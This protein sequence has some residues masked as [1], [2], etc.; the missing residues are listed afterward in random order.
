MSLNNVNI[1][2]FS[3]TGGTE[4]AAQHVT[5]ALIN[6]DISTSL[7]EIFQHNITTIELLSTLV[8]MFPVYALDAPLPIYKWINSLPS[9]KFVKTVII[10]VSGGGEVSPNTDCRTRIIKL[11]ED[12]GFEITNEYMLCMP[13]NFLTPTPESLSNKL[14]QILPQKCEIIAHEIVNGISRRK[15]ALFRDKLTR[16]LCKPEKIGSKFFGRTLKV[17]KNCSSCGLCSRRCPTSNIKMI[18]GTPKFGWN[19][20]LCMR[21]MYACPKKAINPLIMRSFVLKDGFDLEML[22]RKAKDEIIDESNDL[23]KSLIWDGVIKY[24]SD[25]DFL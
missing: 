6:K 17:S 5:N 18:N 24:V 20:C 3:G 16:M 2:Y 10:S 19:C 22:Q 25:V 23:T 8:L 14:F 12:K 1:V 15:K 7:S 9:V 11:L 4:L 21:C 13:A